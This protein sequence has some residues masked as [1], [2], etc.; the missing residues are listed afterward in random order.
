M[1]GIELAARLRTQRPDIAVIY[2]TGHATEAISAKPDDAAV[3]AKPYAW[4]DLA[5][6]IARVL[7]ARAEEDRPAR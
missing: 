6:A 7:G 4:T 5:H 2:A 3:L 1:N